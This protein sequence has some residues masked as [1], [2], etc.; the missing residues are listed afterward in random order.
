MATFKKAEFQKIIEGRKTQTRRIHAHEWHVGKTY[1]IRNKLFGKGTHKILI[2]RKFKQRLGDITPE[3]VKKEGFNTLEEFKQT[4][5]KIYGSWD[6]NIIVTVYEFKMLKD[7]IK[8][9]PFFSSV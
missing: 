6:P 7:N 1:K 8:E 2:T 4:W 3:D 5:E 9:K